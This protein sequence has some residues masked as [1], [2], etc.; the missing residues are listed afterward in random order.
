[1]MNWWSKK[2]CIDVSTTYNSVIRR[3]LRD[4]GASSRG[5]K[6]PSLLRGR[7][8]GDDVQ[9]ESTMQGRQ[10]RGKESSV[11]T[12]SDEEKR[13]G[14]VY[15]ARVMRRLWPFM[16]PYR[17]GL[18]LAAVCMVGG[19]LSHLLAPYV[20]KRTLDSFIATGDLDGLTL[21]VGVYIGLACAG[22]LL[23]YGETLLI[24]RTAQRV[25][26]DLRQALFQHLM[27]LDMA[28]Y[29]R[30]AIGRLM[31][32]VQND[33][34]ALQDLFTS[35]FLSVLGDFLLLLGIVVILLSM[36]VRLTLITCAVLPV[37]LLLTIYW[38]R[39]SRRLFRQVRLTLAQ[40]NARLQENIAGVRVIQSL[41]SEEN[42]LRRFT[43]VNN[44]HFAANLDTARLSALF[45]PTIELLSVL[46]IALVVVYG[47]PLVMAGSLSAGTFVAFVLYM[48]RFFEPLR[49]LGF[50]WTYLQ[51]AMASGE[52]V[53]EIL[54]TDVHIR[55]VRRPVVMSRLR[56]DVTLQHVWFH[57]QPDV[58]AL[59]DLC[60]HVP[61]GQSVA[62]VGHTGAGKTTLV[63]LL[64]RFYDVTRGAILIDGVDLRRLSL[65]SLRRQMGIVLQD[66]FLFSG[67]VRDNMRY[68][69]P[70]ASDAAVIAAAKAIGVHESILQLAHGYDTQVHERGLLLSHGQRQLISFVR[71]LLADP[72]LLILDEATASIDAETEQL[73]QAGLAT[74]LRGRTAFII[75]H[76]LSTVQHVDRII[77][78]DQGRLVESGTHD[79][80]LRQGGLYHRLYAMTY[81]DFLVEDG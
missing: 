13:Y 39:H 23:Q 4:P 45:F 17:V 7:D 56:G 40:V 42:N 54:D 10:R 58:P 55:E 74:L 49:D 3:L 12:L 2:D 43:H 64:A 77:V 31:S 72:R 75:A 32:R 19:S 20:I 57:Y 48:H 22:W 70:D 71:A 80:L 14:N 50:R 35:G 81:A 21:M 44:E 18:G 73:I 8:K 78:L 33:V 53:F 27:R 34:G 41:A 66:P 47:G 9:Q 11:P 61:A 37:G 79:T 67:T 24:T 25:L 29:D 26:F 36:H 51:M 52:R 30:Q 6:Q 60:L 38:R 5:N 59:Q 15:D 63:H 68:G 46:A 69:K 65:E 62:L 1:M 76:R 16:A 28:F